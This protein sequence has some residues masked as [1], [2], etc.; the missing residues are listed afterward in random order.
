MNKNA[1]PELPRFGRRVIAAVVLFMA[2]VVVAVWAMYAVKVGNDP[3]FLQLLKWLLNVRVSEMKMW[4]L[5]LIIFA[6][7]RLPR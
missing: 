1:Q 7:S 6:I 4:H 3:E 2:A 5:L